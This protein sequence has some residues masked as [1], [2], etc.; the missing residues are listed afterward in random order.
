MYIHNIYIPNYF[1]IVLFV[2]FSHFENEIYL[3]KIVSLNLLTLAI[4]S[5][6]M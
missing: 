5:I 3:N 1:Q 2:G 4:I 6:D